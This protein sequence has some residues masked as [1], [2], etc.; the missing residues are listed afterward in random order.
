MRSTLMLYLQS[1]HKQA[2]GQTAIGWKRSEFENP[3][4]YQYQYQYPDHLD[5]KLEPE[6]NAHPQ[7]R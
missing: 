2:G 6:T 4:Q 3:Y 7:W 1:F 5:S